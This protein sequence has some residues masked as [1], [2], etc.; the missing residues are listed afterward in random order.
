MKCPECGSEVPYVWSGPETGYKDECRHCCDR[1]PHPWDTKAQAIEAECEA[2]AKP[3][4]VTAFA[5]L[6]ARVD[7]AWD[8]PNVAAY[9]ANERADD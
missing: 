2:N 4:A 5:I 8:V 1:E 3:D 6:R 7:G 9:F